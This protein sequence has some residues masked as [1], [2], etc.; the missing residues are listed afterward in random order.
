MNSM[1][2]PLMAAKG[3]V[4]PKYMDRRLILWDA[5]A[6]SEKCSPDGVSCRG[7]QEV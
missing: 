6:S 5:V 7:K 2:K 4:N 1:L 3:R